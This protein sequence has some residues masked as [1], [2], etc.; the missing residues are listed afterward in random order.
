MSRSAG[1][2]FHTCTRQ[3]DAEHAD[4]FHLVHHACAWTA[5]NGVASGIRAILCDH[6][7]WPNRSVVTLGILNTSLQLL[8]Y[9]CPRSSL[10][11]KESRIPAMIYLV[12]SCQHRR[13]VIAAE[14]L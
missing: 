1:A 12:Q 5:A 8:V 2:P 9:T 14:E 4:A 13:Y 7:V 6:M 3:L 10:H 11:V